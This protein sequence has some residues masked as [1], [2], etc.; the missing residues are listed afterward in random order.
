MEFPKE[1]ELFLSRK[2]KCTQ[3]GPQFLPNMTPKPPY[4]VAVA[5]QIGLNGQ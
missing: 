2:H 4:L 1:T 5:N 3:S